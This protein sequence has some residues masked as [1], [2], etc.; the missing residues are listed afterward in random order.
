M[1]PSEQRQTCELRL[2]RAQDLTCGGGGG[3]D[4]GA[5]SICG[6]CQSCHCRA[7]LA[8]SSRWFLRAGD[9][10][11]RRF[12]TG[13][14]MRCHSPDLLEKTRHVL[15]AT[16]AKDFT[17]SRSRP[18]P[19]L[20]GD[21]GTWGG[22]R[23]LD[24]GLL[25]R[26]ML[27]T[28]DWFG[29]SPYWTKANY[30]LGLLAL[31]SAQ[32]LHVV[33]NLVR[34]LIIRHKRHSLR[35]Q[36]TGESTALDCLRVCL[37]IYYDSYLFYLF[38]ILKL[39]S[40]SET[41][42]PE[43]LSDSVAAGA[44]WESES[45]SVSS[46]DPA[47]SVI[48]SSSR[49][50]SGVS[51][52][53]DFVRRLPVHLAKCI[54]GLLDKTSLVNCLCVSRHWRYLAEEIQKEA[55]VR[56][57]VE[58]QAMILQGT[59]S[60]GVNPVYA[61][62]R[63]VLVP[64]TQEEKQN[65][66][67][68][69]LVLYLL[70]LQDKGLEAAYSGT[71]TKCIQ[72][73]ERNVY[74]GT[75]N[76]LVLNEHEDP[77]RVV[78]FNGGKLVAI[79][80]KDRHVR[81]LDMA[82]V[83]EV[84]PLIHGHAGSIR[85]VLLCEERGFVISAS[86]DLS[87]R[88]WNLKTGVCM[89]IFR[90][91]LGTINCLDLHG[92][93][94]VSGAKDCKVKV[95]NVLT[96]KSFSKL[97]FKHQDPVM[98]VKI[99]KSCVVSSCRRGLIKVWHIESGSLL[100]MVEGH[101]GAVKCLFFDQWHILSGGAD[102]YVM[103]WSTSRD[104]QRCLMAFRHPK[105]VHCLAFLY[106][107]VVS[108]CAD[109][110]IRIFD[111]LTGDCLRVIKANSKQNP[112]LSLHIHKNSIVMNTKASILLFQFSEVKWDYSIPAEREA[113]AGGERWSRGPALSKH[114]YPYVRAQRM[115]RVGSS[116][117]KI[118]HPQGPD[119]EG[120]G[121]GLSHHAG[122]LS[123]QNMHRAQSAQ[124]ASLRPATWGEFVSYRRSTAYIDLQPE[125]M[126]KP[127]SALEPGRPVSGRSPETPRTHGTASSVKDSGRGSP[128]TR[129]SLARSELLVLERVR[130]RGPH[131][132]VSPEHLLLTVN[133]AHLS[134]H[135]DETSKNLGRNAHVRDAWA[136]PASP[137]P[138]EKNTEAKMVSKP[139]QPQP[140]DRLTSPVG[141]QEVAKI[142]SPLVTRTL[143][144]NL[145]HSLHR[146][147]VRSSIPTPVLVRPRTGSMDPQEPKPRTKRPQTWCGTG[148]RKVGNF[149]TTAEVD[150]P[151]PQRMLMNV[152]CRSP[153]RHVRFE[154]PLSVPGSNTYHPVDPYR[155]YSAFR[156]LTITQTKEL[157]QSQDRRYDATQSK[158][159][160]DRDKQGK[161]VW[162]M[163]VKGLPI[164][165]F[166]KEGQVYAP[167]LGHDAYI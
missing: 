73:E 52:Y 2:D 76:I 10:C 167:E 152:P 20:P 60:S 13:L 68:E 155:E 25:R 147:S 102:G 116:N 94:L 165:D 117:R 18:Q 14:I 111:F 154:Q 89:K 65:I 162:L 62:I 56:R 11:K 79:G 27:D 63:D 137:E 157:E 99:D 166:I 45:E 107:R 101:R 131:H 41:K 38:C 57:N 47:L 139:S 82:N 118:F 121:E 132:P 93:R 148:H 3:G 159:L 16:L 64:L 48:P 164:T 143:Q 5:V 145:R 105:E 70:F 106:L 112:V 71:K 108:G 109:G 54:L 91:H 69:N 127:P 33:G 144:L 80:S 36:T 128:S 134:H 30:L 153:K 26:E 53:R 158:R 44:G 35:S 124:Q 149:T 24:P 97:K 156:L 125:F 151:V 58:N 46:E 67:F 9:A 72:M 113:E 138:A 122:S 90:G 129:V 81:L 32:L 61:K 23:A 114:P 115:R 15:R 42:E 12:V 1:K 39:H 98:C 49:S 85:A 103:A 95:W 163:K 133:M 8:A 160:Q 161:R 86:Y 55:L 146:H 7:R 75:Y 130:K 126:A 51:R 37:L 119:G 123:A 87:I 135:S 74:C 77:S 34:V 142:Y 29:R 96:G 92:N 43:A 140:Q 50:L 59:S 66:P 150:I 17:Y 136:S 84:P 83:R 104:F 88:C 40:K 120:H 28:W 21:S 110:K 141:L 31:C 100:K 78:H 4:A 22:D 6:R 19:S